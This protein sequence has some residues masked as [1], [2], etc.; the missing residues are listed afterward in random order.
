V[1][2]KLEEM[3]RCFVDENQQNLYRL[4]VEVVYNSAPHSATLYSPFFLNFGLHPRTIPMDS[5]TSINPAS[6]N[7]LSTIQEATKSSHKALENAQD[8]VVKYA[9]R[10]RREHNWAIDDLVLLSTQ[11]LSLD[12]Y[13]GARNLMPK[14][15]GPFPVLRVINDV[16]VKLKTEN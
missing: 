1:N 3:L 11:N 12:A 4:L 8:S 2:I 10:S 16:T 5:V 15:C 13:S 7:I 6:N 14:L 9:I